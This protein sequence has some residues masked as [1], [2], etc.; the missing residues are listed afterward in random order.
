MIWRALRDENLT[1]CLNIHP[2]RIGGGVSRNVPC[3]RRMEKP[4]AF[5]LF[6]RAF[7]H[8]LEVR[9]KCH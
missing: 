6:L 2:A 3:D 5:L 8:N 1:D 7:E 4:D 9:Y